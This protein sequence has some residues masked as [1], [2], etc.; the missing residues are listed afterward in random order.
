M[1]FS[2]SS[3]TLFMSQSWFV[4]LLLTLSLNIYFL[5]TPQECHSYLPPQLS[6]TVS[7]SHCFRVHWSTK[8][9]N[10]VIFQP[11]PSTGTSCHKIRDQVCHDIDMEEERAGQQYSESI[12]FIG[13]RRQHPRC[14]HEAPEKGFKESFR[15]HH[16]GE[17]LEL[18]TGVWVVNS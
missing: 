12:T 9:N 13:R 16:C 6:I 10:V 4:C 18:S 3:L 7:M 2:P 5:R 1:L 17:R 8:Y 15:C 14:C 11:S